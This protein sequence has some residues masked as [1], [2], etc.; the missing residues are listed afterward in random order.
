MKTYLH[1]VIGKLRDSW[2]EDRAM[3]FFVPLFFSVFV[4]LA[5]SLYISFVAA[6]SGYEAVLAVA[7]SP[8]GIVGLAISSFAFVGALV[9]TIPIWTDI[10]YYVM[11]I[12]SLP[13]IV[14]KGLYNATQE[15]RCNYRAWKENWK[16]DYCSGCLGVENCKTA[17]WKISGCSEYRHR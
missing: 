3:F 6:S 13:Y 15:S 4:A 5:Y 9:L 1:Y 12:A 10:P 7:F 16:G 11:K 17:H 8:L 14:A 2:R